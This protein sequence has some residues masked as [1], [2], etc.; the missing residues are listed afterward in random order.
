MAGLRLSARVQ[1]DG[2][3]AACPKAPPRHAAAP[4]PLQVQWQLATN[5]RSFLPRLGGALVGILPCP[6]DPR[7][8]C[9][10]QV[11]ARDACEDCWV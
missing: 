8:Y 2:C 5:K 3:A 7:K 4:L 1:V 11:C 9:V 10:A 6:A